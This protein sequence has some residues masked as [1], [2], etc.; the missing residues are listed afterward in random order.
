MEILKQKIVSLEEA[1]QSSKQL[2]AESIHDDESSKNSSEETR[3]KEEIEKSS[4]KD[5]LIQGTSILWH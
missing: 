3:D 2:T 5:E 4:G 1:H